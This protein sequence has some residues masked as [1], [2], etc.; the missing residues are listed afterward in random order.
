[1]LEEKND[2]VRLP[3]GM[4]LAKATK[5]CIGCNK[6]LNEGDYHEADPRHCKPCY[7]DKQYCSQKQRAHRHERYVAENNRLLKAWGR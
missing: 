4:D 5:K 3:I 6:E 7:N 1:M 2:T